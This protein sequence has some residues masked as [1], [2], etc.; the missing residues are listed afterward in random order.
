MFSILSS[1][2]ELCGN[3]TYARRLVNAYS[4]EGINCKEINL[5]QNIL[6]EGRYKKTGELKNY[7]NKI[8]DDIKKCEY[9]NIHLELGLYGPDLSFQKYFLKR[10]ARNIK[11]NKV[12]ITV[13]RVENL[14]YLRNY[15]SFSSPKNIIKNIF[16]L[17]IFLY[18]LK[19][20]NCFSGIIKAFD[21]KNC[22]YIVHTETSL[23]DLSFLTKRSNIMKYPICYYP[24]KS[25]INY[26]REQKYENPFREFRNKKIITI[27]G[28][29]TENKNH[30]SLIKALELL[31]EEYMLAINGSSHPRDIKRLTIKKIK[32]YLNKNKQFYKRIIWLG[33]LNDKE[34]EAASF[35][36]DCV[37][38]PYL[39]SGLSG[40]GNL[41]LS[42]EQCKK[43]ICSDIN[44][45]KDNE[46]LFNELSTIKTN[47]L[48]FVDWNNEFEM[49]DCI[50]KLLSDSSPSIISNSSINMIDFCNKSINFLKS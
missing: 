50:K 2:G 33:A 30:I 40:S 8:C 20:F 41:A 12:I 29:V 48:N 16:Q 22:K 17:K 3:A 9:I 18:K 43:I 31:P 44:A 1:F 4:K 28:F 6:R 11:K 23:I 39:E 46:K 49:A 7:V 37:I 14:P 5:N 10:I 32:N 13:H 19:L 45:F 38:F 34:Y 15:I 42:R 24:T 35:F 47:S 27:S 36:S 25:F 21:K 26:V